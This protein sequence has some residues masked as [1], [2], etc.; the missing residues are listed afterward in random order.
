MIEVKVSIEVEPPPDM[1]FP[2]WAEWTNNPTW[3]TGMESCTWTSE[4]PLRVGSTYDQRASMMGRSIISS[5]E[6]VELDPG[7]KLRIKPTKS[8]LPLDITRQ[9]EPS[10][11]GGTVLNAAIR[12]EPQ[13]LMRLFNPLMKRMVRKTVTADY[14]RLKDLLNSGAAG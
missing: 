10:P 7:R 4:P 6:V 11:A 8:P 13:G 5:F 9:V 1:V 12:G 2:Y 14:E 3:Q